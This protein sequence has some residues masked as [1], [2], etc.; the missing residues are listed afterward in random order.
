MDSTTSTGE[1]HDA[2]DNYTTIPA[3]RKSSTMRVVRVSP[4]TLYVFGTTQEEW[5]LVS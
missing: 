5:A 1:W 3:R 2:C 4:T